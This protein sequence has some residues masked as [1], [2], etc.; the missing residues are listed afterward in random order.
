M[1]LFMPDLI[2]F[3]IIFHPKQTQM[4]LNDVLSVTTLLPP[5]LSF[6][7]HLSISRSITYELFLK[8]PPQSSPHNSLSIF[9]MKCLHKDWDAMKF[10]LPAVALINLHHFTVNFHEGWCGEMKGSALWNR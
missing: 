6:C 4:V 7:A 8:F 9:V 5:L 3:V 10:F 2:P 1:A